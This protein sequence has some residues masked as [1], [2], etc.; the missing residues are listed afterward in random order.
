MKRLLLAVSAI[1]GVCVAQATTLDW[2]TPSFAEAG[3]VG[4]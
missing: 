3:L 1:A 4:C 2:R